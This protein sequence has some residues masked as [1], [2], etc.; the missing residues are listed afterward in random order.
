M[1]DCNKSDIVHIVRENT[2]ELVIDVAVPLTH[3]LTKIETKKIMNYENL[4]LEIK[5]IVNLNPKSSQQKEQSPKLPKIS[6]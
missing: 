1:V 3:S 5:N 4:A 2:T 6:R